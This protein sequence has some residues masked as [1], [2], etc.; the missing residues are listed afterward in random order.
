MTKA[1]LPLLQN[2]IRVMFGVSKDFKQR[3]KDIALYVLLAVLVL[4]IL[5]AISVGIYYFAKS[6][7]IEMIASTLSSVMFASEVM[8]LFFGVMSA[9]SMLFFAKDTEMLMA[10]PAT[11]LDIF[12]SKF[13]TIYLLHVGL[14]LLLQLPIILAA[15]IGAAITNVG[16]YILGFLGSALTPFI[17]LFVIA[18]IAIPLG[19]VVSYFKRNNILGT[20]IVLLLFGVVFGG[21]YYLIFTVQSGLQGGN[22]DVAKVES[23]IKIMSYI[24]YPNTYLANSMVTS[25]LEA[26][27]NFAIFFAIIVGLATITIGISA[28]LYKGSARRGLES[29]SK[30]GKKSKENEVKSISL[31]LLQRDFKTCLGDTSSAINYLLGLVLPPIIMVMV[32]FIYGGGG[33]PEEAGDAPL[34]CVAASLAL[35]FGCGMNYFAIV[36]F[37]R[38]GRQ[39][40]V[41]KMLPV[42]SKTIVGQKAMLAN[43]YTIVVGVI[44]LAS[45]LIAKVFY[46]TAL[47]LFVILLIGGSAIN[48]LVMYY[49]L[50]SPNFVWNTNKELFKNNS[51]SLISMGFSFPLVI[52]AIGGIIC[53][54]TIYGSNFPNKIIRSCLSLLPATVIVIVYL[55][56]AVFGVYPK[57]NKM[58]EEI[59]I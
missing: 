50:K 40:D 36:A 2:N 9:V 31:S 45:M 14:A 29:G 15:G 41:L 47:L 46:L 18:I 49:D 59:E 48:I 7:S 16:Y 19:Y 13:I 56:I 30:S 42:Q 22:F 58:Y 4:P 38:E 43:V 21:Y 25:G 34:N 57:L 51:K 26:F 53:F 10:L 54:E 33:M 52:A 11:G 27:K 55:G 35:I 1:F 8:V 3:R 24:I 28:V 20:I 39:I 12:L 23:A 5:A 17:P 37:S 44:L 6:A 32:S